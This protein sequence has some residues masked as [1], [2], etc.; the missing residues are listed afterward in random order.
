MSAQAQAPKKLTVHVVSQEGAIFEGE[1]TAVFIKGSEGEL[2]LYPGHSQLLTQVAPGPVRI[3]A[4]GENLVKDSKDDKKDESIEEKVE[5]TDGEQL[6]YISGGI[7]EVQPDCV[8][9]LADTVERPQDVNEQAA[10]DA[11]ASAE[12]LIAQRGDIN[13]QKTQRDLAEAMA[14][15]QV[16][17]MMR[18]KKKR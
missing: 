1:A 18:L 17:E 4:V 14:K 15:L 3:L 2:G 10:L 8:S 11:K 6:L 9:I 16:L 12:Q 5:N 13:Y 7:L